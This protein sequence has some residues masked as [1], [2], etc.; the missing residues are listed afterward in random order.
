MLVDS[1]QSALMPGAKNAVEVCLAVKR[2]EKVALIADEACRAVGASLA[3]AL[4]DVG[5]DCTSVLLEQFGPRP[6]VTAP[7]EVL[8]LLEG[9][10]VGILC[11]IPQPGELGSRMAIVQVI[12]RRQ[13]RYAHMVG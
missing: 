13:I 1:A 6:M 2:G 5:A 10:D 9:A 12:E 7:Q 4:E 8:Q 3:A 11:M